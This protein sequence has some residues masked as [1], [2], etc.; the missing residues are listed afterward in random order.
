ML[1]GETRSQNSFIWKALRFGDI[2][3]PTVML[4]RN[5]HRSGTV[6]E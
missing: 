4:E 3:N 6:S 2:S 5:S 1:T